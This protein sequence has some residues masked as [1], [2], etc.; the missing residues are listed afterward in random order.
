MPN[1]SLSVLFAA[2]AFEVL[3][4]ALLVVDELGVIQKVN[5][6]VF[7]VFGYRDFEL[8][9][10]TI[11]ILM[12]G[13]VRDGHRS[14]V[15]KYFSD[16]Q[17]RK[18]GS[19]LQLKAVHKNGVEIFVDISLHPVESNKG[20]FVLVFIRDVS[21]KQQLLETVEKLTEVREELEKFTY[22]LTHDLRAPLN[23][24]M[25]LSQMM[26]SEIDENNLEEIKELS[27]FISD[28]VSSIDTL[29]Q[30]VLK[31]SSSKIMRSE[32]KE[33]VDLN[34]TIQELIH[35]IAIP[36]HFKIEIPQKLPTVFAN[37]TA[38][39]QLF[40]NLISN[41][42]SH[43]EK[44]EGLI[45]I[46]HTENHEFFEFSFADNGKPIPEIKKQKLFDLQTQ[47]KTLSNN[48]RHGFGLSIIKEIVHSNKAQKIWVN[49][50]DLGGTTFNFTWL[51]NSTIT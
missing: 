14:N 27:N 30:G 15:S 46:T 23:R 43:N 12:P 44:A 41:S 47:M 26:N 33:D 29:I 2:K 3:P 31:Y 20:L 38:M 28:S 4:D 6:S 18:M 9:G 13:S 25:S 24:V 11:D 50:N 34:N 37:K 35:L 7:P 39:L 1:L 17:S 40:M 45:R 16:P 32:I 8:V 19:G 48:E 42:I 10:K 49:D 5:E 21:E 22:T 36:A 51:K